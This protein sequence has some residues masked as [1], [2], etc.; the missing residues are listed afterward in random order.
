M[1]LIRIRKALSWK[2]FFSFFNKNVS[3]FYHKKRNTICIR[4]HPIMLIDIYV[5]NVISKQEQFLPWWTLKVWWTLKYSTNNIISNRK[6][7]KDMF[8]K[9]CCYKVWKDMNS[10]F[11]NVR[12][13]TLLIV[14]GVKKLIWSW[15]KQ[16]MSQLN[17]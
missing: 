5:V 11:Q 2:Q 15:F 13:K 17:T 12:S 1:L 7:V 6:K 16:I 9:V 4:I 10:L 14:P 8:V 3:M